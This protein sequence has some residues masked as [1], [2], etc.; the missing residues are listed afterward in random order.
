MSPDSTG[1]KEELKEQVD[2]AVAGVEAS[3]PVTLDTS[4]LDE[5]AEQVRAKLDDLGEKRAEPSVGLDSADFDAKADETDARLDDLDTKTARPRVDL[6]SADFDAKADDAEAKLDDLSGKTAEPAAGLDTADFDAK[7]DE[8]EAKLEALKAQSASINLGA[9]GGEGAAAGEAG[10]DFP[11]MLAGIGGGLIGLSPGLGAAAAGMGLLGGTAYMAFGGIEKA[12][13]AAHSASDN[14][15]MTSQQLAATEFQNATQIQQAQES[16]AQAHQQAAEAAVTSAQSIESAEMNLASTERNA[17]ASQVQALQSVTQAQQGVEESD[18]NLSE[19]QYNLTQAW[20]TAQEQLVQLNDQLADSKLNVQSASLAIQQAVY[21]QTLVDQ[22][23]YSTSLDR[24]QAA[25]AVAQAQQQLTDAQDQA[26]D[27]QTAANL[28]NSQGVA[29]SQTVVQAQ[30]AVTAAQ[31]GQTDAVQALTDAQANLKL[32]E[33]NNAA[34]IK[35]AQ[36]QVTQAQQQAAYSQQ[37]NAEAVKEAEL[38]LTDTI[39]EQKLEWAA[40][41]STQ[42]S[43]ANQFAMYMS[44]LTAPAQGLV[45]QILSMKGAWKGIEDAAENGAAKG[46]TVFLQGIAKVLPI[47]DSGVG[48]MAKAMGTAFGQFGKLMQTKGFAQGLQGLI[49]NGIQFANIVL[50]AFA[51]F[52]QEMGKL[53]GTKGAV[54]G[55]ANL[56]AGLATGLTNIAKAVTPF[57]GPLST[58]FT[59]LGKALEPVGTLLGTVIGALAKGLAPIL[60]ALL[61]GF[62]ALAGSLGTG[63]ATALEAIGPLL[64]PVAKAISEIVIALAPLLPAF[65]TM[66][67]Q[68]AQGLLPALTPLVPVIGQLARLIAQGLGAGMTQLLAAILPLMPNIVQLVQALTPLLSITI[69]VA[70]A[71]LGFATNVSDRLIGALVDLVKPILDVATWVLYLATHWKTA[72]D[73]IKNA[74]LTVWHD[75][76][77]PF[78]QAVETGAS[79]FVSAFTTI[80]DKL[81]SVFKT[82]VNFLIKTVYDG[83]IARLWNDVVGAVGLSALKL[84]II[85]ALAA[86]GVV[87]GWSPGRDNHLAAVSG[88]EGILTP[89]ATRAVGGKPAIDA[90]NKAYPSSGGGGMAGKLAGHQARRHLLERPLEHLATAGMFAAGGVAGSGSSGGGGL[91]GDI[92]SFFGGVAHDVSSFVGGAI[93]IGKMVA[94]IATGNTSA[95]VNAA[96]KMIGTPAAGDLGQIMVGIPKTLV[97]DLASKL[98]GGSSG[99]LPAGSSS[100]I[101]SLPSNWKTIGSY[102]AG[103]GFTKYAAAGVAGNINAESSG[104]PEALEIGGGGGGGLIQW[105]PYPVSYITGNPSKDL[106]TQLAAILTFGGGPAM[107]NKGTSPS[108]AAMIYQDYYERPANLSASLPER[109]ASANAVYKAM[110]W[111]TLDQGGYLTGPPNFTGK[112][113]AVLTPAQ[114]QAF[115]ALVKQMTGQGQA[116]GAAGRQV[117]A[118]FNYFGPQ[119]PTAEMKAQMMRDL[120]LAIGG[121]TP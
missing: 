91:F 86:G 47:I 35:Q 65:G 30:Q 4:G 6:D 33:L 87:P 113:E 20:V 14:V 22:N 110:G 79:G 74:V 68:I 3:I 11:T 39:K 37:Q 94:A 95:F 28:A 2:E 117:N 55:I 84:P 78:W 73:D 121:A 108:N 18:Y 92:G 26:T 93:D 46:F 31:Y 17:A 116:G 111:G 62:T 10:S 21:N 102:L 38:N 82:P 75:V 61:P 112:P 1:F 106:M 51:Q 15:G 100:A 70:G 72:W 119:Q 97:T 81:E 57:I 71:I 77:D 58:V 109:M 16:V 54:T 76:I 85:P 29:G 101:G 60:S 69:T 63:L 36:L 25:L 23:A 34:Q 44:K 32:T 41:M 66:I 104:D 115:V 59:V 40:M 88:G 48:K 99:K 24:Q 19:A 5:Q 83:G 107:V 103:H 45:N 53:G 42:N 43:S 64:V 67:A 96:A 80:W 7:Y 8:V 98:A 120:A 50:P 56:L 89:Q 13:S 9:S 105:T 49:T 114:S 12:L 27:A 118:S 52:L 90:L